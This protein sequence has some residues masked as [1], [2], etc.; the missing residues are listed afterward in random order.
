MTPHRK[1]YGA[2][3]SGNLCP[4]CGAALRWNHDRTT[5]TCRAPSKKDP[6]RACGYVRTDLLTLRP[7][8]PFPLHYTARGHAPHNP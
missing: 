2:L 8:A 4:R 7:E 5:E 3:P 1:I 6:L